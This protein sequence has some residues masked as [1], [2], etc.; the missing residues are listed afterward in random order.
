M[1]G[2]RVLVVGVAGENS[3]KTVMGASLVGILRREGLKTAPFKPYAATRVWLHPDILG[4]VRRRRLVVTHDALLYHKVAPDVSIE[5]L[6]P[7]SLLMGEPDY[8][9]RGWRPHPLSLE[10]SPI[11]QGVLGRVS[12]CREDRIDT[13]HFI[14][15]QALGRIPQSM[16]EAFI[17]AAAA[18]KPYPLRVG[19]EV[20]ENL[21]G[22][23]FTSSVESCFQ[24]IEREFDVIV[25]ESNHDV[26]APTP[27][28]AEPD[29]VVAVAPGV[30][31][32]I[33]G[34]RYRKS[35]QA[36]SET[37]GAP[38]QARATVGEVV[39]LTGVMETIPLPLLE[40]GELYG[41][42]DIASIVEKIVMMA[43]ARE[44]NYR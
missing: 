35:L 27:S 8:S 31:G 28:A 30:A 1:K 40:E 33:D 32:I 38:F 13:F 21:A 16:Q 3:G 20:V 24:R 10:R 12:L 7:A 42:D 25:I 34:E 15:I 18:L 39:R 5:A 17:D 44:A 26:P 14:N 41:L 23:G 29:I 9:R 37:L 22:G 4:E 43:S 19:D 11:S 2:V 36:L 6:N